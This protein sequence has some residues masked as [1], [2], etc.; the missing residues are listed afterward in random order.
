MCGSRGPR[1]GYPLHRQAVATSIG[2]RYA[3]LRA[4]ASY[5]AFAYLPNLSVISSIASIAM[6]FPQNAAGKIQEHHL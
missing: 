5:L 2:N 3:A 1:S 4:S 6:L